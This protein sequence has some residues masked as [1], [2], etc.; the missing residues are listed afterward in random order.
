MICIWASPSQGSP[1]VVAS[2][3]HLVLG[4]RELVALARLN[5]EVA[6]LP[7]ANDAGDGA[8]E[9]PVPKTI[10]ND[11]SDPIERFT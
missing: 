1:A 2:A 7:L 3:R 6:A 11:L 5:H 8:T 10:E 4:D 9:M